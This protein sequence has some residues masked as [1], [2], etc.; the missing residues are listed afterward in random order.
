MRSGKRSGKLPPAAVG[1]GASPAL[2]APAWARNPRQTGLGDSSFV[3]A[4]LKNSSRT[5]ETRRNMLMGFSAAIIPILARKLF[6][7]L[8][9]Q[10]DT[11][12]L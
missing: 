8:R 12:N 10:A 9:S 3:T 6:N 11:C 7:L 4:L 5:L 1:A 2:P